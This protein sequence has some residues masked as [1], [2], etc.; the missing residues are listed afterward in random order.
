[1]FTF[2]SGRSFQGPLLDRIQP[3]FP[4]QLQLPPRNSGNSL[5]NFQNVSGSS[6][7]EENCLTTNKNH[8]TLF[9]KFTL[10]Q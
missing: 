7:L 2:I 6:L 9:I 10:H 3:P 4:A 5:A 1:M 8:F